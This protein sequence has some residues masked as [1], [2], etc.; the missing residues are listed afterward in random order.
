M[1]GFD[2]CL[3]EDWGDA[4]A[5]ERTWEIF[6]P[7]SS[8]PF[9]DKVIEQVIV[10]ELQHFLDETLSRPY[11]VSSVPFNFR[12]WYCTETALVA[13]GQCEQPFWNQGHFLKFA[14]LKIP[15]P[16]THHHGETNRGIL[17]GRFPFKVPLLDSHPTSHKI[18]RHLKMSA[19]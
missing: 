4:R 2:Y 13:P 11:L 19:V 18:L 3:P 7:V 8:L 15:P 17:Q 10:K 16:T 5:S 14:C 9:G 1:D 6:R 12:T